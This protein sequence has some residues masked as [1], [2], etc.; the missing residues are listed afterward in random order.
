MKQI[1][2]QS[3]KEVLRSEQNNPTV[4]FINVCTPVEYNEKHIPG[5]R[6]VPLDELEN[7][8]QEFAQ[9]KTVYIHCRSGKRGQQAIEKLTALGVTA[10]LVN[11]EGGIMA[12][13]KS[14]LPVFSNAQH[15]PLEQQV[16][17][18]TGS[19]VLIGF[20]GS[21][22][23]HPYLIYIVGFVGAGLLFAGLT[24]WCGMARVL[25]KM[26]WNA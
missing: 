23:V 22:F 12:W 24:G 13:D 7:R 19:L 18:A 26:P 8:Y 9:K 21:F 14:G 20:F 6:S 3:F 11:V 16:Q 17:I 1:S 25:A 15:L 10:D 2:V 4:D 5:V